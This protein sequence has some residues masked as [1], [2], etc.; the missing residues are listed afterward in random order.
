MDL[1][2]AEKRDEQETQKEKVSTTYAKL[3]K[4]KVYIENLQMFI[5][6]ENN[7]HTEIMKISDDSGKNIIGIGIAAHLKGVPRFCDCKRLISNPKNSSKKV[8]RLTRHLFLRE[9]C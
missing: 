1:A 5:K 7:I 6:D 4:L 8:E 9:V 3:A 2:S